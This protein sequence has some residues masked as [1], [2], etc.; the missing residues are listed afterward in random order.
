MRVY[1]IAFGFWMFVMTL[2]MINN[3]TIFQY[4]MP[5]DNLDANVG[6]AHITRLTDTMNQSTDSST[7]Y[8]IT[9]GIGSLIGAIGFVLEAF[10]NSI[11]I[12]NI[13]DDY[14]V[15]RAISIPFQGFYAF[16]LGYGIFQLVTGR[17]TKIME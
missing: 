13:A 11:L 15:P 3:L 14:G 4:T 17:S 16:I 2:S 9:G 12:I 8:Q 1:A 7:Y 5:T 6:T 10:P